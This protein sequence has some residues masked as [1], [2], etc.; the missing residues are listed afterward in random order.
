MYVCPNCAGG[1]VTEHCISNKQTGT[2]VGTRVQFTEIQLIF[3]ELE[4]DMFLSKFR[5]LTSVKKVGIMLLTL[6]VCNDIA[7]LDIN[8]GLS[9]KA[10]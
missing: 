1:C 5:G 7:L 2:N 6:L 10:L 3:S 8:D 9:R 4:S